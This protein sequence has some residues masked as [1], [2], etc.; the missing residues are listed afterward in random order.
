MFCV[1]GIQA[2]KWYLR[3]PPVARV[4]ERCEIYVSTCQIRVRPVIVSAKTE[5][6][7]YY[8]F[9]LKPPPPPRS[10]P[11]Q[12]SKTTE[13]NFFKLG[14]LIG[15]H[16]NWCPFVLGWPLTFLLCVASIC[17]SVFTH[18]PTYLGTRLTNRAEIWHD[19]R[20]WMALSHTQDRWRHL[21]SFS[22]GVHLCI[23]VGWKSHIS[24]QWF[25]VLAWN[26]VLPYIL[27][28]FVERKTGGATYD[29]VCPPDIH[30][31]ISG[32]L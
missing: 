29:R 21:Q 19:H 17:T 4:C 28:S 14:I 5:F 9:S 12:I 22:P 6:C 2:E 15:S 31:H 26:F 23:C 7:G 10:F 32:V 1:H 20:S 11:E 8:V 3:F 25:H 30:A 16:M 27:D 18:K 24:Q 13:Q